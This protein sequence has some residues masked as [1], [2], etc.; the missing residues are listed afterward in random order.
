L[1]RSASFIESR[2]RALETLMREEGMSVTHQRLA[3]YRSLLEDESHPDAEHLLERVRRRV[4]TI[5]LGTV[6]KALDTLKDLGAITE[7]DAPRSATRY[8]AVLEPHHHLICEGCGVIVDL[9]EPRYSRL[10]LPGSAARGFQVAS[11]SV[12]FRGLCGRCGV[13]KGRTRIRRS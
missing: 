10:R 4:P 8:E 13:H 6:Y 2:V 9:H 5:S 11:C 7:V 1:I 3:V 12:Q